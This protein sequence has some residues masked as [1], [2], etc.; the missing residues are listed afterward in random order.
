[1]TAEPLP[2]HDVDAEHGLIDCAFLVPAIIPKASIDLGVRPQAFYMPSHRLIWQAMLT[3]SDK[4]VEPDPITVCDELDRQGKLGQGSGQVDRS[5]VG[6]M[7]AGQFLAANWEAYAHTLLEHA[8]LRRFR[9][10]ALRILEG[11]ERRDRD[12]IL[13]GEAI[14]TLAERADRRTSSPQEL[15]EEVF[16]YLDGG[17]PEAFRWPFP[18]LDKLTLGGL[19][20]G[21]L[22]L[23][24][25]HPKHGKS[26]FLDQTLESMGQD[27]ARV[28]L[29]INEM[30]R[31]ERTERMVSRL[32]RVS[33]ERIALNRL[34][35]AE[36]K[37]IMDALTRIPFGITDCSGWTAQDV[38]REVK[39]RRYDV[40]G[41]DILNR[42]PQAS[43]RRD[44]EEI[45][46][47][48]NELTKVADCAVLLAAHL[49]RNRVGQSLVLPFPSLGDLRESAM[50]A[51]DADFTMFVH[52]D[53]DEDTGDPLAAG[54]I[55]I[56]AAR[57]GRPGGLPVRLDGD[58]Q[59]FEPAV[60]E[61][62]RQ[63][64]QNLDRR[65]P[66]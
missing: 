2:P 28:H 44:L 15:A 9:Q 19:H 59:L 52:R 8:E 11:V 34:D 18:R 47:S 1:M 7:A 65:V 61:Q 50:L 3:L 4:G 62:F 41:I 54:V 57:R 66:A 49:N 45:S 39:R 29:F 24:A 63:A 30:T 14:V 46:R 32:A 21:Q 38:A 55:R 42:F 17:D 43:D 5:Q 10:G 35:D 40:V 31:R 20:R 26:V 53:Q 58:R 36:R 60:A 51:A 25:G 13:D 37:R 64:A 27:G 12:V 22:A 6:V 33:Y 48:L 23:V 56:A 16:D